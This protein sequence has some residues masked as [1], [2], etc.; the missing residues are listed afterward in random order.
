MKAPTVYLVAYYMMKPKHQRVNTSAKG[1]MSNPDNVAY[2]EQI[3]VTTKLKNK[4]LNTAKIILNLVDRTVYR[5]SWGDN[6]SFDQLFTHFYSGYQKYLDPVI[7]Q[8]G[9]EMIK[10][11]DAVLESDTPTISSEQND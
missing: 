11:E 2:E 7:A 4:D 6:K 3:A 10:N 8:L 5:N 9:Y 1:W